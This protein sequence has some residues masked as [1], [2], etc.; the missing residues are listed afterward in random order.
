M[1]VY[2]FCFG[3]DGKKLFTG[4]YYI[5]V[6]LEEFTLNKNEQINIP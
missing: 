2:R 5:H 1:L 4:K 6:D 3:W